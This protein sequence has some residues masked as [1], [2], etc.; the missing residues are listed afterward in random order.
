[1]TAPADI[2]AL[3]HAV[4]ERL[5]RGGARGDRHLP[6]VGR[7]VREHS[8]LLDE[9]AVSDVVGRVLARTAGLGPLDPLLAD[10]AV[11]EVMINGPGPVWVERNGELTRTDVV[12][13]AP[14]I[15]RLLER[16]VAPLGLRLDRT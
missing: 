5:L 7:L 4:H 13:D 8:P 16:V 14:T 12:V 10:P 6:D 1:M 9:D 2:E 3:S 15:E 11:S